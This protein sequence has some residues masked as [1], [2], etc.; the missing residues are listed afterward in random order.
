MST[1]LYSAKT[2]FWLDVQINK[3]AHKVLNASQLPEASL[4]V[5]V[6]KDLELKTMDLVPILMNA[7]RSNKLVVSMLFVQTLLVD[8]RV[9]A[10]MV[11]TEMLIMD[12]VHQRNED[13]L[14]TKNV[15]QIS[16]VFNLVNVFARRHSLLMLEMCVE[17][18]AKD[19]AV[20]LM[21][22]VHHQIVSVESKK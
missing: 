12:C 11:T 18:H 21:R 22:N 6:Q 15:E 8:L 2:V 20:A 19:L 1:T 7:E 10:P 16:N 17:T 14:P 5:H 13:V 4:I 9:H 3:N